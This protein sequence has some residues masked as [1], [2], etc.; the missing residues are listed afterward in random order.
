MA[1]QLTDLLRERARPFGIKVE[2]LG[3]R[4]VILPGEMKDLL[5]QA[6]GPPA[7]LRDSEEI[8]RPKIVLRFR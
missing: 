4:D 3:I 6:S 2:K 7:F 5:F 1:E 8:N